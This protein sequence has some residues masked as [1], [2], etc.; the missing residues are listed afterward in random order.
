MEEDKK[1]NKGRQSFNLSSNGFL[2]NKLCDRKGNDCKW[3]L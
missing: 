1:Q 2:T 3:L